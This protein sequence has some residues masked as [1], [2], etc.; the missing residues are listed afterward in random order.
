MCKLQRPQRSTLNTKNDQQAGNRSD[1]KENYR[2]EADWRSE[3]FLAC[4]LE[5]SQNQKTQLIN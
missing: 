2:A 1:R 5:T 4:E 3:F